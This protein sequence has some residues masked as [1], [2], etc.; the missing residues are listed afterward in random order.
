LNPDLEVS[1]KTL[2]YFIRDVSIDEYCLCF[3]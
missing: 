1:G 3:C 2:D